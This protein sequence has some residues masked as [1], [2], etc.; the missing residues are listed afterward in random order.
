MTL[1]PYQGRS[2]PTRQWRASYR[3]AY[4]HAAE[5]VGGKVTE[6][7][8]P[9]SFHVTTTRERRTLEA[10]PMAYFFHSWKH[11]GD[12][13]SQRFYTSES[14]AGAAGACNRGRGKGRA[15][16]E[17]AYRGRATSGGT[18]TRGGTCRGVARSREGN[19]SVPKIDAKALERTT[20]P[21]RWAPEPRRQARARL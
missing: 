11:G 8:R 18:V 12:L 7:G 4:C 3:Q 17:G 20:A 13:G 10:A 9:V 2:V 19:A 15:T 5:A 1:E 16:R 21:I 14:M 6:D